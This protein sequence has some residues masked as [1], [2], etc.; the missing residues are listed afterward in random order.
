M[1]NSVISSIQLNSGTVYDFKDAQARSDIDDLQRAITGG[2]VF[3][4]TTTSPLIDGATTKPIEIGGE[5]YNQVQ[6]NLVIHDNSEFLWDGAKWI[7]MGDLSTLGSLAYKDSASGTFTPSGTLTAPNITLKTAGSTTTVTS[8]TDVGTL[9]ELS[10]SVSNEV[11]TLTFSQGTL[12]TKGSNTT[13]KTG[14]AA[15]EASA[16]N[17]SGSSGTVTVS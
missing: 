4:G 13:V 12:P 16:P 3:I 7:E 2:I 5:D 1:P 14:D 15:Y 17:F 8:I 11:L 10:I 6:G 9:P